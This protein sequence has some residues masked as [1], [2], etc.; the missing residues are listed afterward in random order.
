MTAI[1]VPPND[2]AAWIRGPAPRGRRHTESPGNPARS[3]PL[4][5]GQNQLAPRG[6]RRSAVY[7]RLGVPLPRSS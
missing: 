5:G 1:L 2:T 7:A 4:P 6:S 3:G